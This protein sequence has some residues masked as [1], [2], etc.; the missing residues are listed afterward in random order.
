MNCNSLTSARYG[1]LTIV[2]REDID[3]GKK[4]LDSLEDAV[5]EDVG[6]KQIAEIGRC[7][8]P[9][10]KITF[11]AILEEFFDDHQLQFS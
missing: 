7:T 5:F 9:V 3:L 1:V 8:A 10:D 11:H 4:V 2:F 6:C